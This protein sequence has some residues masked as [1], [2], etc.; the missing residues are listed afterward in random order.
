MVVFNV[1]LTL[2]NKTLV[3][4]G[5]I[6][7]DDDVLTYPPIK[8]KKAVYFFLE[9]TFG[10]GI[11]LKTDNKLELKMYIINILEKGGT[12]IIPSFAEERAQTI[13]F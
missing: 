10:N 6:G 3:F 1:A 11:H 13:T 9:S 5:D 7:R 12:I 4:S 2:K 8:P